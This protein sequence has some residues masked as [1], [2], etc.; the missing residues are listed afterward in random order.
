MTP[1]RKDG[2]PLSVEEVEAE[3]YAI[4]GAIAA[5]TSGGIPYYEITPA[6]RQALKESPDA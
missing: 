4:Q 6:G 3:I 5:H 1:S 2:E